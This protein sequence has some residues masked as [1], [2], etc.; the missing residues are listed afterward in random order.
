M[1]TMAYRARL[2]G[3]FLEVR[4]RRRGTVVSCTFP[5]RERA[6]TDEEPDDGR[7]IR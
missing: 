3:G 1:H 7:K 2:I 4:R 5:L 6:E